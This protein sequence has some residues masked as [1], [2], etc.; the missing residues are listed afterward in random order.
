[1]DPNFAFGTQ[2]SEGFLSDVWPRGHDLVKGDVAAFLEMARNWH[3]FPDKPEA[4]ELAIRRLAASFSRPGC[5]FGQEDHILDVAIALE[6]LYGGTTCHKLA[7]RA[8]A[9]LG[10]SVTEQKRTYEQAKGFSEARSRIVHC[11]KQPSLDVL[12]KALEAGRNLAC[13]T[14]AS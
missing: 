6:V 8:A 12:D 10:T 4:V 5:R 1:M 14:L 7:Q 9:L 11:K 3:R 13:L 2:V